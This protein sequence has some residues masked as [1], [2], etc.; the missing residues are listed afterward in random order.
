MITELHLKNFKGWQGDHRFQFAPITG[1]F[2]ANSSGK[3]SLIQS[4]LLLKQ[5]KDSPD[6]LRVFDLGN[7]A[8][9][10]RSPAVLGTYHDLHYGHDSDR[11]LGVGLSWEERNPVRVVDAQDKVAPIV[12]NALK[13]D[14]EVTSASG[15]AVVHALRYGVDEVEFVMEQL[16]SKPKKYGLKSA[17]EGRFRFVRALGRKWELPPPIKCYGFPDQTRL[18]FQNAGFLSD[19]ELRLEL[20]LDSI[21]YLG[22]LREDPHRQYAWTGGRPQGVGRRG[23]FAVDALIA[24]R[25]DGKTNSRGFS[26]VRKDGT[27]RHLPRVTVENHVSA[28]LQEL[29]LL[30]RFAVTP[31]DKQETMYRVE[32]SA[33]G[34]RSA[35]VLLPDIGFGV[36]QVLPVL[37]LLAYVPEGSIVILEQPEIHLHPAVQT[38]LADV[39]IEAAKVRR[40]QIIVESHSEHVLMRLQRRIAERDLDRNIVLEPEDVALYFFSSGPQGSKANLLD[41]DLFGTIRNWP[42][43]F[44]GDPFIEA[45]ERSEAAISR[46]LGTSRG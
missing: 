30:R 5:T 16:P 18:Y 37:T 33:R 29:G 17:P 46:R 22:P 9:L 25:S 10:L 13:F 41:V 19:L 12:S 11:P 31:I 3:S 42:D 20:L 32:V 40:L 45:A 34:A 7:E 21:Y 35:S 38:G 1:L 44:F 24:S 27:K 23:E 15:E 4:L 39:L 28:W 26:A 8:G 36:S 43:N 14:V 2:G 6:R